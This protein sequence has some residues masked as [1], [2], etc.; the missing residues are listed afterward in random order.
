MDLS[1]LTREEKV[2]LVYG[3]NL[4]YEAC[5]KSPSLCSRTIGLLKGAHF[6]NNSSPA[7]YFPNSSSV[8]GPPHLRFANIHGPNNM[9]TCN[10]GFDWRTH[11]DAP[12]QRADDSYVHLKRSH[13]LCCNHINFRSYEEI[14]P[15]LVKNR[16]P[17]YF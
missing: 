16:K 8:L 12:I 14:V 1:N 7:I 9:E 3:T 2:T 11:V 13:G 4:T 15:K 17:F 5:L 10:S 6:P